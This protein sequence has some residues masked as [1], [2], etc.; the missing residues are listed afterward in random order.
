MLS[1]CIIIVTSSRVL[2]IYFNDKRRYF[3]TFQKLQFTPFSVRKSLLNH[4][5]L[6]LQFRAVNELR[7]RRNYSMNRPGNFVND[8]PRRTSRGT[9]IDIGRKLPGRPQYY[10]IT[11]RRGVNSSGA[12]VCRPRRPFNQEPASLSRS[13]N[14]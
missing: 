10:G 1:F 9:F 5:F 6:L 8:E 11:S 2:L 14:P 13:R 12:I 4:F 7:S 3:K